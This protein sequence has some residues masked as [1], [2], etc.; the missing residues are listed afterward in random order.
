MADNDDDVD[1]FSKLANDLVTVIISYL[2]FKEAARTSILSRRW[3]HIWL[4]TKKI[5]FLESF[6]VRDDDNEE[7]KQLHRSHFINFV[8]QWIGRYN[9]TIVK[10]FRLVISR[11]VNFLVQSCISF[12][13]ARDVK[14]LALDFHDPLWPEHGSENHEAVF[15]LPMH[16]YGHVGLESLELFSCNINASRFNNFIALKELSLGWI[17]LSVQ[18]IR[19]LL[20]QCPFLESLS[21][22]KCWEIEYLDIT[23][24]NLRLKRLVIDK[25]DFNQYRYEIAA[26]NLRFWKYSGTEGVFRIERQNFLTEV[27]L[28]FALQPDFDEEIG[29]FLYELLRQ[30]EIVRVLTVCSFLLQVSS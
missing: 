17:Q 14:E 20:V 24:P 30:L 15:D 27:E 23:V 16:V 21:L 8:H 25:C 4:S 12:A 6:F 13:I 11:P 10:T 3:R 29:E 28:D 26:P 19:E 22:K 18:S 2:P 5:E 7:T 9:A 1:M